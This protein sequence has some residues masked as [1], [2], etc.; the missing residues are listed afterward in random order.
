MKEFGS[1]QPKKAQNGITLNCESELNRKKLKLSH[2]QSNPKIDFCEARKKRT[3]ATIVDDDDFPRYNYQEGR[4][5]TKDS[6]TLIAKFLDEFS[7]ICQ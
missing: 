5:D 2:V 4:T 3:L 1:I 7:M 6:L